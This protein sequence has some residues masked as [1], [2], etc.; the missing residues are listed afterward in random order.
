MAENKYKAGMDGQKE[1]EN[2]LF[3]KG[4][5][6]ITKNYRIK[7][8]EIDLVA[9]NEQTENYIIFIEVK[10]RRSLRHGYPREAVGVAKQR[11]IIRTALHYISAYHLSNYDFRFDVVE[12]LEKN[13]VL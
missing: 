9:K 6:I 12:V 1:A 5:Q 8:G 3:K 10:F 7:S 11:K 13:K 4:Y 2:Y